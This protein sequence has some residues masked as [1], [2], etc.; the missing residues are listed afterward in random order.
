MMRSYAGSASSGVRSMPTRF[1]KTGSDQNQTGSLCKD[2]YRSECDTRRGVATLPPRSLR[3]SAPQGGFRPAR[4]AAPRP[5]PPQLGP[6]PAGRCQAKGW[7][8]AATPLG[9]RHRSSS[10]THRHHSALILRR[11]RRHRLAA[12]LPRFPLALQ[13]CLHLGQ[14]PKPRRHLALRLHVFIPVASR[15]RQQRNG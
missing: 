2:L 11:F 10:P 13:L 15:T 6:R 3:G 7:H 1:A 5:P 14:P 9:A 8:E 4:G 12:R